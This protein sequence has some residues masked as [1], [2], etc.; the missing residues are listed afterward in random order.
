MSDSP[1]GTSQDMRGFHALEPAS[2]AELLCTQADSGL[3]EDEAVRRLL[4]DGPNELPPPHVP[5]RLSRLV[6]EM[7]APMSL[8]LLAAAGVA[9]L[10]LG[11][12]VDGLVIVAIVILNAVIGMIQEGRAADALGALRSLETPTARV[13]RDGTERRIPASRVVVG[14]VV[15]I[16]AGDRVPADLRLVVSDLL[17]VDEALLTGES[18]PVE[19]TTQS[20][21]EDGDP[22]D[23]LDMAYSGT[24]VV[25]G[26]GRGIAVAT[27]PATRMGAIARALDTEAPPTPLQVELASL[28]RRLGLAAVAVA[29][30]VFSLMVWMDGAGGTEAAFLV[31]VALAVA[32]VP[33]GLPTVVTVGLALGVRR[34]ARR[35]A[36]VKRLSAVESLGAATILLSDKTGTLTEN[37]MVVEAVTT[38]SGARL[39]GS[40]QTRFARA[41]RSCNDATIDPP[42]GD[43]VDLA[44]LSAVGPPP[45]DLRRV[46]TRPFDASRRSMAVVSRDDDGLLLVVKGAP[47]EV[48]RR[49]THMLGESG[50][51]MPLDPGDREALE[52][53]VRRWADRGV[54]V[55]VVADRPL[56]TVPADLGAAEH[57]LVV[58][59]LVGMHDPL[60]S[61]A[62]AAVAEA[63][64]AGISVVMVTG[65]HPGTARSVADAA[66]ID[67][68]GAVTGK[69]LR[70]GGVRAHLDRPVFAR[71]EPS[72]KLD[73][74]E[75]YQAEGHVV[76]V[77]GDGVNDGPALRR[78]DI[79]VAMGARGSDVAKEAADLVIVDDDLSTIV[80]AIEEGRGIYDNLRKVV[81]YL[82]AG[83]L[84]EVLVV[85]VGF[86]LMGG[87][88]T[89]L[90]AV[91]LLWLN[92]LTDGLPALAL[93]VDTVAADVMVRAPRPRGDRLL[94]RKRMRSLLGRASLIA[95]GALGAFVWSHWIL[96]ESG[97]VARTVLFTTLVVAHVLYAFAVRVRGQRPTVP[98]VS[99]VVLAVILQASLLVLPAWGS[100][101]DVV[102][103]S[104]HHWLVVGLA[105]SI[106]VVALLALRPRS[107]GGRAPRD[108]PRLSS[109]ERRNAPAGPQGSLGPVGERRRPIR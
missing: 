12:T 2:V 56:A 93:G 22:S 87:E 50:D 60:R 52:E 62:P 1:T 25:R 96:G 7:L 33:E 58:L 94:G 38:A 23:R 66:G 77:T 41:A 79:G 29:G 95:T 90:T 11:E 101:F 10:A 100:V 99:A 72:Q 27:G 75:G 82:V 89:V 21:A 80:A 59:G 104:P 18:L 57:G 32:A 70:A 68:G 3:D 19:K 76:A 74:V 84:S 86:V 35:G 97:A 69:D 105:A 31:A 91:Q 83:N 71:V 81:D 46:L 51:V 85:M 6:R 36:I 78:A 88:G 54:R 43:A 45:P 47:E 107:A 92:L 9:G 16:G 109:S 28:T 63:R 5:G 15:S 40:G 14:D 67:A 48:L 98:L 55:I 26:S 73:L 24:H 49:C 37:R 106:P 102:A 8:L 20:T 30:V 17:E 44:L 53:R 65:D 39:Q 42:D 13:V 108:A 103:V 4:R 64:R 61:G 34:M